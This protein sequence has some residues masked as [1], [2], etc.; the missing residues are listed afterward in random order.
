[1]ILLWAWAPVSQAEQQ[2][3]APP[4]PAK[5]IMPPPPSRPVSELTGDLDSEDP[6]VRAGAARELAGA[7]RLPD[8]T[9]DA[10]TRLARAD[11]E[12]AV[13][14]AAERARYLL[15]I[16]GVRSSIGDAYDEGPRPVRMDNPRYPQGARQ[17][18]ITGIVR[19]LVLVN[20][21]GDVE[22]A[23]I[24][25]SIPELDDAALA[26]VRDWEFE[27]ATKDGEPTPSFAIAP[28]RFTLST[29]VIRF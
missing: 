13:R 4:T 9:W 25:E 26:C 22:D 8:R 7:R 6:S 10:L 17:R 15:V 19:V 29:N 21:R 2:E 14:L 16:H 12:R 20:E 28:L 1:M 11:P 27:P 23:E 5:K 24:I 3:S 18:R